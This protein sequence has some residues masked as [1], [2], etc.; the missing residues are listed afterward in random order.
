MQSG[1]FSLNVTKISQCKELIRLSLEGLSYFHTYHQ[2]TL[3]SCVSL[4]YLFIIRT[5]FLSVAQRI[6]ISE[7]TIRLTYRQLGVAFVMIV[8]C[9]N[10]GLPLQSYVFA[11]LPIFAYDSLRIPDRNKISDTNINWIQIPFHAVGVVMLVF[12]FHHRWILSILLVCIALHHLYRYSMNMYNGSRIIL[13]SMLSYSN[14]Y[15]GSLLLLA[16]F[17]VLPI[18]GTRDPN[19]YLLVLAGI[20][21]LVY[22]KY[23]VGQEDSSTSSRVVNV[24]RCILGVTIV[25]IVLWSGSEPYRLQL[26]ISWLILAI[27]PLC[28]LFSPVDPQMRLNSIGLGLAPP[29]ILLC[30]SYE[31]LFLLLLFIH[32][33]CWYRIETSN[34][35]SYQS[36]YKDLKSGNMEQGFLILAYLFLCF[37]GLGNIASVSSYN[38]TCVR[39]FLTVFSPFTMLSF[40]LLKIFIPFLLVSCVVRAIHMVQHSRCDSRGEAELVLQVVLGFCDMMGIV[41]LY[42]VRNTGSWKQIGLSISHVVIVHSIT[43]A[44]LCLYILASYLIPSA[45]YKRNY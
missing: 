35:W 36:S 43:L 33:I 26:L 16:V 6:K 13:G 23:R 7:L 4:A 20:S 24:Q 12:T 29:F 17:P 44:L 2:T 22:S 42:Q 25:H 30:T 10:Y 9:Y 5:L 39:F 18:V 21:W 11:L 15:A 37:F 19:N 14:L 1:L 34:T 32:L 28:I 40:V 27:S 45:R 31:V 3:L 38:W 41:F 8:F